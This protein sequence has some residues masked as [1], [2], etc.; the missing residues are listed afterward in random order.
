MP[1]VLTIAGSDSGGGA[2]IQADLKT[3]EAIGVFGTS[4]ITC[5]TAQNPDAVTGIKALPPDT[6]HAQIAAV[7]SGFPV[8]SAK[9]GMLFSADIIRAVAGALEEYPVRPLVVDPVM[10]ATSG[11]WLLGDHAVSALRDMLLSRATVVTPNL[12]EAEVLAGRP[13]AT[14]EEARSAAAGLAA[15]FGTAFVVKG[16]HIESGP[17][18]IDV[19]ADRDGNIFEFRTA[20]IKA[21]E[22]HGTG[23]TFSAALTA[24]LALGVSLPESVGKAQSFVARAL[25]RS[26]PAGRHSPL[27][28]NNPVGPRAPHRSPNA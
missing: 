18:V 24:Y 4:A 1:V 5:V 9:T 15:D 17:D 2:G 3:F 11:A 13:I 28:W 21:G 25:A 22:T 7:C 12:A 8:A 16:G 19:L 6:V 14:T 27:A 23:C 10:V 20:R 26:V